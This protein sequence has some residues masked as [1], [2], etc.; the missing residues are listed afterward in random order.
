MPKELGKVKCRVC[1]NEKG[2]FC[3]VKKTKVKTNKAR[4]CDAFIMEMSKVKVSVKPESIMRPDWYWDKKEYLKMVK[5]QMAK[6]KA[7]EEARE[8]GLINDKPDILSK[9]RSSATKDE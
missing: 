2:G 5:E 9:F 1:E 6:E 7:L 3:K 4:H 8:K